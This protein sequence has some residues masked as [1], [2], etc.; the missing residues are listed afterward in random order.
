MLTLS[1]PLSNVLTMS[2]REIAELTKKAHPK[3]TADIEAMLSELGIDAAENRRIY[4]DSMNRPQTEYHLDRELTDT[5][6]TGYSA[7]IRRKVIVRW[8]ELENREKE[9]NEG[10]DRA[11]AESGNKEVTKLAIANAAAK[12]ANTLADSMNLH[13]SAKLGM[14]TKALVMT[15]PEY[16]K[17][18]PNYAVDASE[19]ESVTSDAS[20]SLT[21]LLGHH[22]ATITTREANKKLKVLGLLED[23]VRISS[24]GLEKTYTRITE[25]GLKY[26]V[27][28]THPN[29]QTKSQPLWYIHK[30]PEL[31]NL[32]VN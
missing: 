13:G 3:V 23:A 6:L 30:F 29:N 9:V 8:H 20:E 18:L 22:K 25:K 28:V 12:L 14:L 11:D 1:T 21:A 19:P 4:L 10:F 24:K 27:N 16:V 31:L 26:G 32:I 5:L 15:A 7:V 2:S 17:L